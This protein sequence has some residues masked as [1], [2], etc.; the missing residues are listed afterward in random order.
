[1]E[2]VVATATPGTEFVVATATPGMEFVVATAA[3]GMKFVVVTATHDTATPDTAD[4]F[5]AN[6]RKKVDDIGEATRRA[7]VAAVQP[8][9][10]PP[11][12]TL[13]PTSASEVSRIIMKSPTNHCAL[14]P[15]P[16][17]LVKRVCSGPSRHHCR[18]MQRVVRARNTSDESHACHSSTKTKESH[19]RSE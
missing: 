8:R 3:P 14:D 2:F 13:R 9:I 12:D 11:L 18:H 19:T 10:V 1:M 15:A 4:E 17:W 7:P 16:T 5:A 6:F